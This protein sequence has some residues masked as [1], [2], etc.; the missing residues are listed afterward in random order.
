VSSYELKSF[1]HISINLKTNNNNL[2]V[3]SILKCL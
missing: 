1:V 3:S 2:L